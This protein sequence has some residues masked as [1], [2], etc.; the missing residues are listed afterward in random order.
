MPNEAMQILVP[1][2][3][4]CHSAFQDSHDA[5][6]LGP[7]FPRRGHSLPAVGG[8][9]IARPLRPMVQMTVPQSQLECA[10]GVDSDYDE[11]LDKFYTPYHEF[12]DMLCRL[13]V[14]SD[15]L[16]DVM[17][18][19]SAMV[20]FEAVPLHSMFFPKLWLDVLRVQHVDRKYINMLTSCNYFVDYI[21][22]VLLDERIALLVDVI[23]E[24]LTTFFPKVINI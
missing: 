1:L 8:K 5:V 4:H 2:L 17:V 3:S 11:A 16:S 12:I 15:T 9:G 24:F 20:G 22:A 13:A 14:N 18:T 6:P 21:D 10:R 7:Y 23:Y 19:L